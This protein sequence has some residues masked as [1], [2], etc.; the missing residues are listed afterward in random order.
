MVRELATPQ[1]EVGS[2]ALAL[3]HDG[4][5]LAAGY[6]YKILIWDFDAARVCRSID[7]PPRWRGGRGLAIS[8]DG[9]MVCAPRGSHAMGLWSTTTGELLSPRSDSH[10]STV[11][12]IAYADGGRSIVSA[13]DDAT[14]RVWNAANGRQRWAKRFDRT[15]CLD[16]MAVS[17]DGA[18]IGAAGSAEIAEAGV[19]ILQTATGEEVRFIPVLEKQFQRHVYAI[20]FSPDSRLV[21]IAHEASV[22]DIYDV[23]TGQKRAAIGPEDTLRYPYGMVFSQDAASLFTVHDSAAVNIWDTATGKRCGRQFTALKPPPDAPDGKRKEPRIVG[24]EPR[25]SGAAFAPDLKTLVT[26]QGRDLLVWDVQ[27]GELIGSI[28]SESADQG[29][30]IAFSHNGRLLVMVDRHFSGSDALRVI[31]LNSGRVIARFDSGQ[32]RP[33]CFAFSP[34]DTRL[35]TGMEDGTALVWDLRVEAVAQ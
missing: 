29:G 5:T 3:S 33:R 15:W 27:R 28:P 16:S 31:D 32:G 7:M 4:R 18:L 30:Y 23:A 22:M 1:A 13:G 35:V 25:N 6:E 21:A 24:A 9:R 12:G 26:S 10:T 17:P 14:V 11:L 8:A 20:A 34:D 2:G 19:H